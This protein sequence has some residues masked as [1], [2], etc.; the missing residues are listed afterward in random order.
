MN[1]LGTH[2]NSLFSYL[3]IKKEDYNMATL[4]TLQ[5]ALQA[6]ANPQKQQI[7]QRFFKTGKGDYAEGDIFL[8]I[9]VP[10]QRKL[11]KQFHT[12]PLHDIETLLQ[13]NIHEYR[14]C[15]LVLLIHH[16]QKGDDQIK[17]N[18]FDLY[19][20]YSD[21]W[22]NNWDL[23]DVS[24]PPIV[25]HFIFNDGEEDVLE[26]LADSS[27]LWQRRISIIST[28]YFIRQNSFD[29]TLQLSEKLLLDQHDLIH[30]AT[31]WMLREVG[32]RNEDIL[33][34]FLEKYH[35][36]MPRTMFRYSVEKLSWLKCSTT[37]FRK[38]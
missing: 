10:E 24:A 38:T 1:G 16:Y 9:T 8:G 21:S 14:F 22:I 25:G 33:L 17:K 3:I 19:L 23:V 11:I 36:I 2:R 32:K 34:D 5:T 4:S 35:Q 26:K 18:I 27:N 20:K 31:G 7:L 15:A 28:F 12:L 13:N 37:K 30:K 29:K 6:L